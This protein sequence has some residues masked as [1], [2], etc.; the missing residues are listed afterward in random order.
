MPISVT[1]PSSWPPSVPER[2]RIV[3]PTRNGRDSNRTRP[4]KMLLSDC[5]PAMAMMIVA[6]APST[7]SWAT[8][9]LSRP[10]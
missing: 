6:N 5:W 7:R 3:S 9:T 8:G 10:G 4:A 2:S 1:L